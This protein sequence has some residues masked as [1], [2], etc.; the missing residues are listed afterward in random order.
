M[1]DISPEKINFQ[2]V[3]WAELAEI[4]EKP[5]KFELHN[6]I[7]KTSDTLKYSY[8]IA[9]YLSENLPLLL[10]GPTGTGKTTL[11]KDVCT[12]IATQ[13][14][15]FASIVLSSKTTCKQVAEQV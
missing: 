12:K 10:C 11:V 6:I 1:L 5:K 2:W 8:L 13:N 7:V 9:S 4:P 15:Q 3:K 14:L